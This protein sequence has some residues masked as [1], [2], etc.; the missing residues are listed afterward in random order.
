ML[1]NRP[2]AEKAQFK[3]VYRRA[4]KLDNSGH[5]QIYGKITMGSVP[6]TLLAIVVKTY[7]HNVQFFWFYNTDGDI[8][9]KTSQHPPGSDPTHPRQTPQL[10]LQL[11]I[12]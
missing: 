10:L 7:V 12:N 5:L 9:I 3:D 6:K 8:S 1:E 2:Y 4:I 11:E